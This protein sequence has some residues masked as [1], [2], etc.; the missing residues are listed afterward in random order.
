MCDNCV[1]IT[2]S[3]LVGQFK[4]KTVFMDSRA[5]VVGMGFCVTS[6][7]KIYFNYSYENPYNNFHPSEKENAMKMVNKFYF[8]GCY[9]L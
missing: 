8:M 9:N 7:I 2:C 3:Y 5:A 6:N 4:G 1:Y